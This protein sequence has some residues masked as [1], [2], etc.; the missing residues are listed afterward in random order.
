MEK[1]EEQAYSLKGQ[2]KGFL[3]DL[4]LID[5]LTGDGQIL[6]ITVSPVE[7]EI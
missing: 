3:A 1:F 4:D 7:Q 6:Y 5:A 2:D